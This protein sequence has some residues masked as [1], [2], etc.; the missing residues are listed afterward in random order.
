MGASERTGRKAFMDRVRGALKDGSGGTAPAERP[1]IDESI[2]RVVGGDED[3]VAMFAARAQEVGM[4]VRRCQMTDVGAE[5]AGALAEL[6]VSRIVLSVGEHNAAVRASLADAGV[7]VDEAWRGDRSLGAEYDAGAGVTDVDAAIAETGSI[8]CASDSER[9]RGLSLV[10]AAHVA[11]VKASQVAPDL[12]DYMGRLAGEGGGLEVT[13]SRAIITG[14][15]KT[16]DIE[17]VL[18]TGVHG[19]EQVVIVLVEDA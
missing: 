2:L 15:S 11:V 5:V 13:S 4:G 16:A 8:V 19:P 14:P 10:P 6:G 12:S 18:I 9:G 17:G 3:T 7:E 1:E